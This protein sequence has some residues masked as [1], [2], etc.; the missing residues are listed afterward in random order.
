[1]MSDRNV[2]ENLFSLDYLMQLPYPATQ[3]PFNASALSTAGVA[4]KENLS[5]TVGCL[6]PINK[7]K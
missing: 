2:A 5:N 1:M 3:Q 6:R 4:D 7:R